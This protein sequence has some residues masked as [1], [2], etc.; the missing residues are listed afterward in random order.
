MPVRYVLGL[1]LGTSSAKALLLREDGI[2]AASASQRYPIDVPRQGWAE[3]DPEA[4]WRATRAAVR[5]AIVASQEPVSVVSAIAVGGQMHGTVLLDEHGALLRPAIIWPDQRA[6]HEAASL[7]SA[8]AGQG[9]LASLGGG[10]S[11]G[12]MLASLAWCRAHEPQLWERLATALAPKDY[13]RYRL[14]DVL[15]AEPSDGSGIP[16]IDLGSWS[17][18]A[19]AASVADLPLNL[20][21]PLRDS[22]ATSG[23]LTTAA[24]ASLDLPAGIPVYCGGSDQAMGAIGAGLLEPGTLLLSLSTGGQI[25]TPLTEPLA[26]PAH[27]TR[28]LCHAVQGR[29]LAL[30]ATLGA[31]LSLEWMRAQVFGGTDPLALAAGAPLGAGG[32]L[33]LPYLAGERAPLLDASASGALIGLRLDH[34]RAH[35]ARAVLEGIALSLRHALEPLIEAGVHVRH[36][37][38]A[39]GLAQ[40]A[41]FQAIVCNVLDQPVELLRTTEQSALGAALLAAVGEAFF[42][43]LRAACA[44]VVR[45]GLPIEPDSARAEQYTAL[46]Q[47]YRGLYPHLR[48]DMHAL[49]RFDSPSSR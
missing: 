42:P 37:I 7:E 8:L 1:D 41:L 22:V 49:R 19:A 6:T 47:R 20:L 35:L 28:T 34:E 10:V 21:P 4:W 29:Y 44:S 14:T 5:S 13:L 43:D 48:E 25:V 38:L 31:G 15:A 23:T 30:S 16:L 40:H 17:W 12:F 27:G 39:G 9:L 11:P 45:Y 36:L 3:Q 46:Y 26:E 18:S 32:L 2:V 33:F 24:A